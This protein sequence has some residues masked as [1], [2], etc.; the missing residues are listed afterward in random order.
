MSDQK[1]PQ[2]GKFGVGFLGEVQTE[3]HHVTWP[4]RQETIRLTLMVIGVTLIAGVYLGGLDYVF[5]QLM[6][7]IL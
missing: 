2:G 3:L 1:T 7:F 6:G 5:T 4:T